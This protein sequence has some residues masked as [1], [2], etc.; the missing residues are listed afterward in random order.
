M[1]DLGN[2]QSYFNQYEWRT[3]EPTNYDFLKTTLTD[4]TAWNELD[5][6]N[7]IPPRAISVDILLQAND[8]LVNSFIH[9]RKKGQSGL[10]QKYEYRQE[11]ANVQHN[12]APTIA[13]D[14]NRK[15]EIRCNPKPTDW[16]EISICILGWNV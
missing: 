3:P 6:S 14:T 15:L 7:I 9:L 16:I 10:Y 2:Q 8:N 11:V 13:V 12:V 4:D 5:L 1:G